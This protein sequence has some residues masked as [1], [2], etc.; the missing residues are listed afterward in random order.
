[1]KDSEALARAS[2]EIYDAIGYSRD[3]SSYVYALN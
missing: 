2:L 1:M 3:T